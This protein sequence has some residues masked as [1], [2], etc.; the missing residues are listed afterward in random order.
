MTG[1]VFLPSKA[2]L[3][4]ALVAF[5]SDG[6]AKALQGTKQKIGRAVVDIKEMASAT[7]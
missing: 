3:R 7:V 1:I 2:G 4:R 6:V 5:P